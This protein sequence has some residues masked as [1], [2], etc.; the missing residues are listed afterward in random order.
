MGLLIVSFFAGVLT[1][2]SPCVLPLL[3]VILGA[4]I[5][6]A[7]DKIRPYIII[8]SLAASIIVFSLVLKAT[9]LFIAI[10]P[11]VW[12]LFS[13]VLII[14]FGIVTLFPDVW[15][16]I[17]TKLG[18][19]SNSNKL[20]GKSAQKKGHIG[21]VMV[22]LSLGPVFSS[23][24]PTYAIILA[25]VLPASFMTG[26]INLLAYVTGLSVVLLLIALLGQKF[27]S[28]VKGISSPKSKFKKV[29]G[30][31]F[32]FL[33]FAIIM[34]WD[35]DFESAVIDAGIF[36]ITNFEQSILDKVNK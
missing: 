23:C 26:I 29:L 14:G 10:D 22:G 4:S 24:S 13:G 6:D 3:P 19:S 25:V 7:K 28:K 16:N 27:I 1:I 15:K 36:D 35:K 2:L 33:G 31:L 32:L 20:L 11:I 8:L 12:K 21:S 30:V 5:E 9:T 17:S 34:G 18:F